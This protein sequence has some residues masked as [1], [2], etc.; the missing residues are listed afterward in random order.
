MRRYKLEKRKVQFMPIRYVCPQ[1]QGAGKK[2]GFIKCKVCNGEGNIIMSSN[3]P[4]P[5]K[6]KKLKSSSKQDKAM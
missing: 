6:N 4:D 1:C 2:F 3:E 5:T